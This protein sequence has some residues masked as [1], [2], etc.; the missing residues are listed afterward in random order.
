VT[1]T[2]PSASVAWEKGPTG[3]GACGII[4]KVGLEVMGRVGV[5]YR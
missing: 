3:V 1:N 4:Q 2:Q 5:A